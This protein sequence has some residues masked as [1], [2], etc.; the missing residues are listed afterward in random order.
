MLVLT[1]VDK[2][3]MAY[4]CYKCQRTCDVNVCCMVVAP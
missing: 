4:L 1:T 3:S 2:N